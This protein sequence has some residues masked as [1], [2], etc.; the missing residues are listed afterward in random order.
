MQGDVFQLKCFLPSR[1]KGDESG[2]AAALEANITL[3]TPDNTTGDGQRAVVYIHPYA[4]L[5]GQFRNNVVQELSSHLAERAALTIAFNLRG[6]GASDGRTS[7][8]GFGEQEDLLAILD[9]V[10]SQRLILHP[11]HHPLQDRR[12]LLLRMGARGLLP[13]DFDPDKDPLDAIPLP[14][15]SRLLL[16]GY[17]YGSV[18]ASAIPSSNYPALCIDYAFISFPFSVLWM[19]VLHKRSWYLQQISELISRNAVLVVDPE[20]GCQQQQHVP[21]ALFIAGTKDMF[22]S[23]QSYEKW[24]YQLREQATTAIQTAHPSMDALEIQAA[25]QKILTI[26]LVPNADHGWLRRESDISDAILSWW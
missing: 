20:H 3:V 8:T 5:G 16:C 19:L 4:P 17:S 18:I 24:W 21:R 14:N 1:D 25:V 13:R 7:W 23:K 11:R 2:N 15:I 9:M 12:T 22:T 6:A 10:Q 26:R